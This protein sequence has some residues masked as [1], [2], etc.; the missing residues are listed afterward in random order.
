ML[1]DYT[2]N[3]SKGYLDEI[4]LSLHFKQFLMKDTPSMNE[5]KIIQSSKGPEFYIQN[6]IPSLIPS[7]EF[8]KSIFI[9]DLG[10]EDPNLFIEKYESEFKIMELLI[11]IS[12]EML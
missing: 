10:I 9:F 4:F 6:F 12:L 11:N 2:I 5:N 8:I 3:Y 7:P 1:S